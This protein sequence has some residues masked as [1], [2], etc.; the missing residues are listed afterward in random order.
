MKYFQLINLNKNVKA[1]FTFIVVM[2]TLNFFN[3]QKVIAQTCTA[4]YTVNGTV[5]LSATG[6]PFALSSTTLA[7]N[8]ELI[9]DHDFSLSTVNVTMCSGAKITVNSGYTLSI[10][11]GSNVHGSQYM[12]DQIYLHAGSNII[13][14]SSTI[15]DANFAI[16]GEP[17]TSFAGAVNITVTSSTFFNNLIGISFIEPSNT[18]IKYCG[19]FNVTGTNFYRTSTPLPNFQ[20]DP[21]DFVAGIYFKNMS[22]IILGTVGFGTNYFHLFNNW[23]GYSNSGAVILINVVTAT[24][25]NTKFSDNFWGINYSNSWYGQF[26]TGYLIQ[27]GLGYSSSVNTFQSDGAAIT[28]T[29]VKVDISQNKMLCVSSG[30][31]VFFAQHVKHSIKLNT[32]ECYVGGIY[33]GFNYPCEFSE[34]TS[35]HIIVGQNCSIICS[36]GQSMGYGIWISD[37][38]TTWDPNVKKD[39]SYIVSYNT[40]NIY[41]GY[42]GIIY[43]NILE[44]NT[45]SNSVTLNT[46][47]LT[48]N[49]GLV[50]MNY[51]GIL[52]ENTNK[53]RFTC[54]S[55]TGLGIN[56]ATTNGTTSAGYG[57]II[58]GSE[59]PIGILYN[60]SK[61]NFSACNSVNELYDG[62]MFQNICSPFSLNGTYFNHHHY[63]LYISASGVINSNIT[64]SGNKWNNYTTNYNTSAGALAFK[65]MNSNSVVNKFYCHPASS[66]YYPDNSYLSPSS[67]FNLNTGTTFSCSTIQNNCALPILTHGGGTGTGYP[68]DKNFL[69]YAF[70]TGAIIDSTFT[71][72]VKYI[73][74]R[75]LLEDI[76]HDDSLIS[77]NPYLADWYENELDSIA[78]TFANLFRNYSVDLQDQY[79]F[80]NNEIKSLQLDVDS[81]SQF[82]DSLNNQLIVETDSLNIENLKNEINNQWMIFEDLNNQLKNS[83]LSYTSTEN[84]ISNTI[85]NNNLGIPVN[86]VFEKNEKIVNDIYLST[87]AKGKSNFTSG[88]IDT[89]T[90]IANQCP[91]SG[92]DAVFSARSICSLFNPQLNYFDADICYAQG[93]EYR[94]ETI[95]SSELSSELVFPNPASDNLTILL[96]S[97]DKDCSVIFYDLLGKRVDNIK[98]IFDGNSIRANISALNNGQY[99][100]TITNSNSSKTLPFIVMK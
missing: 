24:I 39:Y 38:I 35:N 81:I 20:T 95:S 21:Y 29:N 61:N 1:Y 11:T 85:R 22:K 100:V 54:N 12:W 14:T 33:M 45:F 80:L 18:A 97:T 63:G 3:E 36:N 66:I 77:L 94:K 42:V 46:N 99:Y 57:G 83:N 25:K 23:Y 79:T 68:W 62:V 37:N 53:S 98:F 26:Q 32:I 72:G 92:G 91:L 59:Y 64:N 28:A 60:G 74:E 56:G 73:N 87:I 15:S 96:K 2:T 55:V 71:K 69:N 58:S 8:G 16:S 7:V 82:I 49:S 27:Q 88:Q 47:L 78:G 48:V 65:N 19:T 75:Y 43:R 10:L 93:L 13:V 90:E 89:L 67:F 31:N 34:I 40:V 5:N 86:E 70:A 44:C 52:A 17:F 51:A 41:Q 4:A 6:I 76:L 50:V 84:I 30:I 9:I